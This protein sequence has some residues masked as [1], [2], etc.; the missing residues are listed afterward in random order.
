MPRNFSLTL[1]ALALGL[2]AQV[3]A[4]P[5]PSA[6]LER[7]EQAKTMAEAWAALGLG[8][9]EPGKRLLLEV[10]DIVASG[11]TLSI[12]VTSK[13][14]GTDWMALFA[15]RGPGPLLATK[16]FTPGVDISLSTEL[17]LT[18]TTR[19]RAVVRSGGRYYQV[20]REI[21][22]AVPERGAK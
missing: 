19:V 14:P 1:T 7:A 12:K 20:S 18:Q 11:R 6:A 13:M 5:A 16:D 22:V 8:N 9:P 17:R 4:Q 3:H 10:P 15:E 2:S 21:K